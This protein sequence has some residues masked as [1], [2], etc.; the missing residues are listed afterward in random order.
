MKIYEAMACGRPVVA[1]R[2]GAEGLDVTDGCDIV[3]ADSA[4]AFADAVCDLL[5]QPARRRDIGARGRRLV[6][7]RFA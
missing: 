7:G 5:A 2:V 6:E 1:T 4:E 3:L